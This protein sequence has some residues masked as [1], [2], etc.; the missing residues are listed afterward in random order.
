MKWRNTVQEEQARQALRKRRLGMAFLTYMVPLILVVLFW[1]H[2]MIPVKV[3]FHFAAYA[4]FLHLVFF[5]IFHTN[6]NLKFR[7]PSLTSIQ[8][9]MSIL[10]AL[11]VFY[12]L[13]DGQARAAMVMVVAAPLL[14]GILVLS[15]WQFIKVGVWFF[16]LYCVTLLAIWFRSPEVIVGPLEFIQAIAFALVIVTASAIG[17]FISGLRG[18]LRDRNEELKKAIAR[19]EELVNIDPLTGVWNRHRLFEIL[20]QE[21]NRYMRVNG[22]FSVCMLDIDH[23]KPINDTYG[24]QAGDEVLR[25]IAREVSGDLR[26]IDV[27]GRYGGEEFLMVLPETPLEGAVVKAERVRRQIEALRFP[28]ISEKLRITVSIGV[29]GY[30]EGE[31]IDETLSRADQYLY[32]AKK[33]GRNQVVSEQTES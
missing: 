29:A 28:G 32:T 13:D 7:E 8:M 2:D 24:H 4:V 27:F 17:G 22:D 14:Y 20:I 1:I 10:P 19:I 21:V 5:F 31:D 9:G 6:I 30:R 26:V 18:K 12:F 3:V 23:F 16:S 15:I 25:T 11:W 33:N